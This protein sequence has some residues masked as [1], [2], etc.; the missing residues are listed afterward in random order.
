[1]ALASLPWVEKYDV[2]LGSATVIVNAGY[3]ELATLAAIEAAGFG[4]SIKS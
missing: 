2:K 1:M 4:A 3:D